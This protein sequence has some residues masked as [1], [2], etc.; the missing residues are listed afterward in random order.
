MSAHTAVAVYRAETAL[1]Q[2]VVLEEAQ[3][4]GWCHA[5]TDQ[6]SA[7]KETGACV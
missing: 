1:P 3:N 6:A 7:L 4:L 5:G 2:W